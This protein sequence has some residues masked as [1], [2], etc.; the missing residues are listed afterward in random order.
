MAFNGRCQRQ[1]GLKEEERCRSGGQKL[2]RRSANG[3]NPER[4]Q[5]GTRQEQKVTTVKKQAKEKM[6]KAGANG[7]GRAKERRA[8]LAGPGATRGAAVGR[9]MAGWLWVPC[10]I[11]SLV[12]VQWKQVIAGWVKGMVVY[13]LDT[14]NGQ[15]LFDPTDGSLHNSLQELCV[16]TQKEWTRNINTDETTAVFSAVFGWPC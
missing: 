14:I 5:E 16:M 3:R 6:G 1:T 4:G 15:Y 7:K 8:T 10:F 2:G 9:A 11:L 13:G 12:S